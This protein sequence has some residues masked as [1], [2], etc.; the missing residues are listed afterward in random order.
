ML[1]QDDHADH[2]HHLAVFRAEDRE[3]A[4]DRLAAH[5]IASAIHY[6]L[7]LTQQPAC[8][9]LTP[10]ECAEAEAWAAYCISVPCFPELTAAEIA[11]V[12]DALVALDDG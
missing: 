8:L 11:L 6:P 4:R 7:A 12:A 9:D 1:W 2:V 3:T 10:D 5:G